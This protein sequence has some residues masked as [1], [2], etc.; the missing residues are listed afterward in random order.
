MQAKTTQAP[1]KPKPPQ[2]LL[3]RADE[4]SQEP[5]MEW[6]ANEAEHVIELIGEDGSGTYYEDDPVEAKKI[7]RQCKAYLAGIKKYR[8]AVGKTCN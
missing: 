4:I 5:T 7:A 1:R 2:E 6:L 3:S 8:A